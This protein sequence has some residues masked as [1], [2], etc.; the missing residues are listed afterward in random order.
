MNTS[1]ITP[2]GSA[3]LHRPA[4]PSGPPSRRV[5]AVLYA[6]LAAQLAA[7]S[8]LAAHIS[9]SAAF[10]GAHQDVAAQVALGSTLWLA[11]FIALVAIA[12]ITR[13]RSAR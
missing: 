4:A 8:A 10:A 5:L 7:W 2:T 9:W 1:P 12:T 13:H 3:H 6:A 11:L